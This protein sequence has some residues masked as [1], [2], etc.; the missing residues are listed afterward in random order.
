MRV[1]R[2]RT[3]ATLALLAILFSPSAVAAAQGM[4]GG[5][6]HTTTMDMGGKIRVF[7]LADLLEYVPSGTGSLRADAIGWVGGDYNRLYGRLDGE[8]HFKGP[9]GETAVDLLYGRLITPFW[10]ALVGGR[11][12]FRALGTSQRSTRGLLAVG[13]EGMSTYF[14]VVEPTLYVSNKGEV[15]GRF[16]TAVDLLFTQRLVLEPRVEVNFAVQ[17]VPEFGVGSGINDVE[18][19]ARMRYEIRR[20]F[21]PYFGLRYFRRTGA[22]AGLARSMG[23][24]VSEAGLVAGIR[25]WR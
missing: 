21:A 7:A 22:T 2:T 8:Q 13:F 20:E 1:A 6:P 25:M 17:R 24:T 12:E 23:E 5:V 16:V 15:S 14:F 18:L 4:P 11:V 10:T 3:F 9:G 19:G